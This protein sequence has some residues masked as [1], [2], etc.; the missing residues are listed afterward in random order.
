MFT[1]KRFF[2]ELE[3]SQ[4]VEAIRLAELN[5]SGEIKVHIKNSSKVAD[6]LQEAKTT[7]DSLKMHETA[8]RNAI[9]FVFF[10]KDKKF[11]LYGDQGIHE[12]VHQEFWDHIKDQIITQFKEEKY[13][14]GLLLGVKTCGDRLKEYFPYQSN[15]VNELSNE[16]SED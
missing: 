6:P 8:E 16:I 11:A 10:P 13:L 2:S 5:T 9:L 15:D 12:K 3:E 14:E 7:F 4:L 1:K